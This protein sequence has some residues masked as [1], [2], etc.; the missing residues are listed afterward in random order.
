MPRTEMPVTTLTGAVAGIPEATPVACDVANGNV[1]SNLSEHMW[2]EVSN[3]VASP[4]TINLVTP[5]D[6]QGRAVADDTVTI[7][8][9]AT[10]RRLG[11]F[12]KAVYGNSLQFTG[13]ATTLTVAAY[14]TLLSQ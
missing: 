10:R 3:S 4:G 6:V 9:S 8:A 1:I 12:A 14:Q 13:S 5:G 11:P 7:P 2:L